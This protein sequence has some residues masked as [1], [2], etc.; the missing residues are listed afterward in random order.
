[1]KD[2]KIITY[3]IVIARRN[4][5]VICLGKDCHASA[6]GGWFAMTVSGYVLEERNY[7]KVYFY[8]QISDD[9]C[10][11]LICPTRFLCF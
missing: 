6:L 11:N 4:D 9:F 10:S 8:V 2:I 1:M 5:E 3:C 7:E